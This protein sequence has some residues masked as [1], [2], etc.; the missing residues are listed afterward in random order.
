LSRA[1]CY[2]KN[3]G[4]P[5][6]VESGDFFDDR[7]GVWHGYPEISEIIVTRGLP[8]LPTGGLIVLA[9][10]NIKC[11]AIRVLSDTGIC[12]GS[13]KCRTGET[14][15]LGLRTPEPNGMCARAFHSVHPTAFA[16]RCTD[17]ISLEQADESVE[18][19][20]PGGSVVY[21]LSRIRER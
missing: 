13:A 17:Q 2:P 20:C 15:V 1:K 8:F 7:R 6:Y 19:T 16:M 11:E 5:P 12:S 9:N 3:Y 10:F 14:Y 4:L 21:R 18:V